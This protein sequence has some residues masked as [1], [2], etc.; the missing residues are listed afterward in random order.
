[1]TIT[2]PYPNK[3]Q[4]RGKDS[5]RY[6]RPTVK[7]TKKMQKK[8]TFRGTHCL[9]RHYLCKNFHHQRNTKN[10]LILSLYRLSFERRLLIRK[11]GTRV[12]AANIQHLTYNIQHLTYNIQLGPF[13]E[14]PIK[15]NTTTVPLRYHSITSL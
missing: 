6:R 12:T 4:R 13:L 10:T 8:I 5:T 2:G 9:F 7:K 15:H 14:L 3:R 1:M 11:T